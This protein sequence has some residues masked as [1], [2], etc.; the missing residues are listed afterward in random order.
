MHKLYEQPSYENRFGMSEQEEE[1]F[2]CDKIDEFC[3]AAL[4]VK[5][6]SL[7]MLLFEYIQ[8][9]IEKFIERP[10]YE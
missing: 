4:Q 5:N 8:E 7:Y 9:N 1:I 2:I 3:K 6:S 10:C